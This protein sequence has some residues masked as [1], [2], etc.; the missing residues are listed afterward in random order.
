MDIYEVI[1]LDR[2]YDFYHGDGN[3]TSTSFFQD[4]DLIDLFISLVDSTEVKTMQEI[5]NLRNNE[6]YK[7]LLCYDIKSSIKRKSADLMSRYN[8]D[9]LNGDV[10][11]EDFKA[12]LLYCEEKGKDLFKFTCIEHGDEVKIEF[13]G[14]L[15]LCFKVHAVERFVVF[16]EQGYYTYSEIIKL[17]EDNLIKTIREIGKTWKSKNLL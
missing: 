8:R 12:A 4:D 10:S 11:R 3:P 14:G 1:L 6:N 2:V 13:F 9:K 17:T 7:R 16:P 15:T 5:K